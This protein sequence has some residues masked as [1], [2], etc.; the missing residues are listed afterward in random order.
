MT[1]LSWIV[2]GLIAGGLA[3]I[4]DPSPSKGGVLGAMVLGVLGAVLG[5][6]LSS[7]VFGFTISAFNLTSLIVAV[8]GSLL[9]LFLQR[10]F[11]DSSR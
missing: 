8:L 6:L 11:I 4:I 1:I 2:F 9:L 10:A 5:G 3:N 7:I